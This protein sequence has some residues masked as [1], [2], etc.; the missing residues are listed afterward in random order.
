MTQAIVQDERVV[1]ESIG[2]DEEE[3]GREDQKSR[4]IHLRAKGFSLAKIAEE[5]KV[6]KSTPS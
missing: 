1:E 5:L 2:S 3:L 6:S 4:F